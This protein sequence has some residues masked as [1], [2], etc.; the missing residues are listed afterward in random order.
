MDEF[1]VGIV[2]VAV[3][4][5]SLFGLCFADSYTSGER[6]LKCVQAVH[7]KPALEINLICKK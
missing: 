2:A 1:T 7:D 5:S 4:L 6:Q 3:F